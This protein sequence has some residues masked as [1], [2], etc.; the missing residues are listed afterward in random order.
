[1]A[2]SS[3][4][5]KIL[6]VDDNKNIA[7]LIA[8]FCEILGYETRTLNGGK[9]VLQAVNDFRPNLITLDLVMPDIPGA[10]VLALLKKDSQTSNIPVLIISCV[11]GL[12]RQQKD[13]NLELS[14][15]IL[16]KPI[17]LQILDKKIKDVLENTAPSCLS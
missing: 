6:I 17:T 14:Q 10:H 5:E 12:Q 13:K 2:Q 15:G 3:V 9:E 11:A 1:M 4:K 7:E 16:E 8:E